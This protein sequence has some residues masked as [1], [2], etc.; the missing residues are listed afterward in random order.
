[1]KRHLLRLL[2]LACLPGAAWAGTAQAQYT[3]A[4]HL[5]GK[6]ISRFHCILWPALLLAAGVPLP[7]QVYVHGFIYARGERLSK[8]LGNLVDPIDLGERFGV[9]K[10]LWP[11]AGTAPPS[12]L[13]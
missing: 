10:G 2:C 7:R 1:M 4:F 11:A 12:G 13:C 9:E 3:N 8:S 6:D 5:I